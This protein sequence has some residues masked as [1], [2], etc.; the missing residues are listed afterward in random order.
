MNFMYFE[1][2]ERY[3]A[4]R[5]YTDLLGDWVVE[6]INGKKRSRL[7]GIRRDICLD[8]LSATAHLLELAK[9]RVQNRHY[10]LIVE[11]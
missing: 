11:R 6:R 4:L 9:Y 10:Q 7:G 2:K 1:R 3:F 8:R 5:L